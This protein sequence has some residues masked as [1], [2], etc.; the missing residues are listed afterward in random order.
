MSSATGGYRLK[1]AATTLNRQQPPQVTHCALRSKCVNMA[2][3]LP[4]LRCSSR[5]RSAIKVQG[6]CQNSS[7]PSHSDNTPELSRSMQKTPGGNAK[8][9]NSGAI[10]NTSDCIHIKSNFKHISVIWAPSFKKRAVITKENETHTD[11]YAS[12]Y[13]VKKK[14]HQQTTYLVCWLA[15]S[16]EPTHIYILRGSKLPSM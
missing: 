16:R 11:R 8:M 3:G 9:K 13:P 1:L 15:S 5:E 10:K 7:A 6:W 4:R 12:V 2:E 14:Q